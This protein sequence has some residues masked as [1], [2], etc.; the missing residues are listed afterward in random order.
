VRDIFGVI[1]AGGASRRFGSPKALVELSGRRVVDRVADALRAGLETDE[2]GAIVNDTALATAIGLP[3]RPDVLQD[4]G[5][6]AGVHAALLWA[7]ERGFTHAFVAGCDMPLLPA[8]LIRALAASGESADIVLPASTGPRG[9]EPLCGCY[10]TRCI[11]AIENAVAR[12]DRRM[13]GFHADVQVCV[14]PLDDVCAHGDPEHL[15][16]NLNT[17]ADAAAAEAWLAGRA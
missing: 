1:S 12:G 6:I 5:A 10:A 17:P 15:F 2:I 7:Q 14:M 3:H 16:M 9:L 4:A 11:T 13:I 8:S